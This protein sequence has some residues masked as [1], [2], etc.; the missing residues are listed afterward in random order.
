MRLAGSSLD[1]KY[2]VA[3]QNN[4][5]SSNCGRQ[6]TN[7]ECTFVAVFVGSTWPCSCLKTNV[8]H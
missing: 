2:S 1:K 5:D 3:I 4:R 7:E 6:L 8:L